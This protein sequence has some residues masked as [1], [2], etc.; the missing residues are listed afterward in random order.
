MLSRNL[1]EKLSAKHAV[2]SQS[3]RQRNLIGQLGSVSL[4]SGI[5]NLTARLR[6]GN[7][8]S[9]HNNNI[10]KTVSKRMRSG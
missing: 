6:A 10:S 4:S 9:G 7:E 3:S 5:R 2:R 8:I 1:P